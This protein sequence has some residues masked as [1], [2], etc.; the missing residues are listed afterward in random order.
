MHITLSIPL[1]T[2]VVG[3]VVTRIHLR[4]PTNLSLEDFLSRVCARMDLDPVAANI[5]YR[6]LHDP[7]AIFCLDSEEELQ[8]AMRRGVEKIRRARTRE[9]VMEIHNLVCFSLSISN[10][11]AYITLDKA[12]AN[13]S[14]FK[15]IS[16][17][18]PQRLSKATCTISWARLQQ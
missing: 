16:F 6:F 8:N 1:N 9:V 13:S 7:A 4:L 15:G 3:A 12:N 18:K 10:P 2:T 5:G 11:R 17:F 14:F